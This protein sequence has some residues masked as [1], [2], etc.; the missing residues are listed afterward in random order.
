MNQT[1]EWSNGSVLSWVSRKGRTRRVSIV[2]RMKLGQNQP[3]LVRIEDGAH[4]EA[5]TYRVLQGHLFTRTGASQ[6]AA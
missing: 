5:G 6:E 4:G 1:Q 2:T 3:Y